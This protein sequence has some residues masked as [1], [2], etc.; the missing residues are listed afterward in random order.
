MKGVM[1]VS[2]L[3]GMDD[4]AY[5][6]GLVRALIKNSVKLEVVGGDGIDFP[7]WHGVEGIRFL[8]LKHRLDEPATHT[9]KL[10]R[11]LLSYASLLRYT[12]SASPNTLHIIWNNKLEYLDLF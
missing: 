12:W 2:L 6:F 3:T 7:E 10:W 8:N 9:V 4:K 1:E 5:M 11:I